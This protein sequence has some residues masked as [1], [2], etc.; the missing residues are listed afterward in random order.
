MTGDKI[1]RIGL[2]VY[3]KNPNI[4]YA[5]VD[6]NTPKPD[7]TKKWIHFIQKQILKRLPKNSLLHLKQI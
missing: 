6:N 1:G 4:I 7:T 3:P 2:A 5:V